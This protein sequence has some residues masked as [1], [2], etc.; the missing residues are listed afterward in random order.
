MK[1]LTE[2]FGISFPRTS[3]QRQRMITAARRALIAPHI[4]SSHTGDV[5][6]TPS[7]EDL[8][9]ITNP[10]R[11]D[12]DIRE[13]QG[14]LADAE[15][16]LSDDPTK[17]NLNTHM[18]QQTLAQPSITNLIQRNVVFPRTT[19]L[20][21]I[22]DI[23]P[24]EFS[25]AI[26]G[27]FSDPNTWTKK[28]PIVFSD[29]YFANYP[30]TLRA[31]FNPNLLSGLAQ[32]GI[33]T[34]SGPILHG[35][36]G[37]IF[38]RASRGPRSSQ[39]DSVIASYPQDQRRETSRDYYGKSPL[40]T[41]MQSGRI[42]SDVA[43]ELGHVPIAKLDD[44]TRLRMRGEQG[45]I[46]PD[47]TRRFDRSIIGDYASRIV[48]PLP[49]SRFEQEYQERAYPFQPGEWSAELSGK[50]HSVR[51]RGIE[52]HFEDAHMD[53]INNYVKRRYPN[54]AMGMF[55]PGNEIV[56]FNPTVLPSAGQISYPVNFDQ[57]IP[58]QIRRHILPH[59]HDNFNPKNLDAAERIHLINEAIEK[60]RK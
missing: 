48:T 3:A 57:S 49:G 13:I 21:P 18:L 17:I 37:A 47:E 4:S 41:L 60:L 10:T 43:H 50:I 8:L 32:A 56:E 23:S 53:A 19:N 52:G 6:F 28:T 16:R 22:R 26:F 55:L 15:M 46:T 51:E 36:K 7:R 34:H 24:R 5:I 12:R 39:M 30:N 2:V 58:T 1:K 25:R 38:A 11:T 9:R 40:E 45:T 59:L 44:I 42:H 54:S 20:T 14:R 27:N 31:H 29:N 33:Y 35:P